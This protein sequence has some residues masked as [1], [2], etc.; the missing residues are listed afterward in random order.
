MNYSGLKIRK[1]STHTHTSGRQL[2]MIFLEVLD[3]YDYSDTNIS[4]LFSRESFLSEGRKT[5]FFYINRNENFW[6]WWFLIFYIL[7]CCSS[8]EQSEHK[9]LLFIKQ[10]SLTHFTRNNLWSE[11]SGTLQIVSS[12]F[13]I[14]HLYGKECWWNFAFKCRKIAGSVALPPNRK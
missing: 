12:L 10:I 9:V 4:I 13:S 5:K 1:S 11:Q 7:Y 6:K 8:Q 14:F 3:H 2:K